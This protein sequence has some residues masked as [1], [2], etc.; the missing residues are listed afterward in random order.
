MKSLNTYIKVQRV[1]LSFVAIFAVIG[2]LSCSKNNPAESNE[3][4]LAPGQHK[5][6]YEISGS[7]GTEVKFQWVSTDN[8]YNSETAKLPITR[9]AIKSDSDYVRLIVDYRVGGGGPGIA[10]IRGRI[11]VDGKEW[12][13]LR[14]IGNWTYIELEGY[15]GVD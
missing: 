1:V 6:T 4:E 5:I 10:D 13:A 12:K 2:L 9:E 15:V 11:W 8:K 14:E 7:N 3:P